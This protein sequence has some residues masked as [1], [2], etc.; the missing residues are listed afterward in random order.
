MDD[1]ITVTNQKLADI[2]F[3]DVFDEF[4]AYA[5]SYKKIFFQEHNFTKILHRKGVSKYIYKTNE[6]P[7]SLL[8]EMGLW[9]KKDKSDLK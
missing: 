7:F 8:R 2:V 5:K 9:Y 3:K 4:V 6:L 1:N